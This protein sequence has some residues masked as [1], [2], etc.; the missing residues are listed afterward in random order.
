MQIDA[1]QFIASLRNRL[2][3]KLTDDEDKTI[4]AAFDRACIEVIVGAASSAAPA[5]AH[6]KPSKANGKP[7]PSPAEKKRRSEA[8]KQAWATRKAKVAEQPAEA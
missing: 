2:A 8:M 6:S 3:G 5:P 7:K 1:A 4:L